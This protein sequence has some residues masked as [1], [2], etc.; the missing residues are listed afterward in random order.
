[1]QTLG[2]ETFLKANCGQLTKDL[3]HLIHEM[4]KRISVWDLRQE[5]D[6]SLVFKCH[7]AGVTW[8]KCLDSIESSDWSPSSKNGYVTREHFSRCYELFR[9]LECSDGEFITG[10]HLL[11]LLGFQISIMAVPHALTPLLPSPTG[12]LKALTS[13]RRGPWTS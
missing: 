11:T 3:K 6:L 12:S 10:E 8:E 5:A 13:V 1:M 7:K 4:Q 9:S 2:R